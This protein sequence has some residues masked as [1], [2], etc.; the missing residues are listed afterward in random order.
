MTF[1]Y[2]PVPFDPTQDGCAFLDFALARHPEWRGSIRVLEGLDGRKAVGRMTRLEF[3]SSVDEAHSIGAH[4]GGCELTVGMDHWHCHMG[5]DPEQMEGPLEE[6]EALLDAI[7]RGEKPPSARTDFLFGRG[8][9]F[10]ED[11]IEERQVVIFEFSS[12]KYTMSGP[13]RVE[14]IEKFIERAR[15]QRRDIDA[16]LYPKLIGQPLEYRVRSFRGTRDR[17]ERR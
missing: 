5:I 2:R 16:K 8:L 6:I 13:T 11:L 3:T 1:T 14:N 10:I 4:L 7:E 9:A 17:V 12:G 15:A